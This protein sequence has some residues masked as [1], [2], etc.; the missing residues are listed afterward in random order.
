MKKY[1]ELLAQSPEEISQ[2][3]LSYKVAQAELQLQSD[4]LST[5]KAL[6]EAEQKIV[7][8]K[9]QFPLNSKAIMEANNQADAYA[10][11]LKFLEKL[12]SELF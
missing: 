2:S 7:E 5:K 8:L 9:K 4:V 12:K 3:E 10:L 11:G 6:N 1:S